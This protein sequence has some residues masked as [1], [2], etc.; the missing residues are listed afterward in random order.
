M[1]II[2]KRTTTNPLYTEGEISLSG[3]QIAN[4]VEHTQTML[5][6]GRYKVYIRKKAKRK[7]LRVWGTKWDI[8]I[9]HSWIDAR[10]K[11]LI[12]IGQPLIPGAVYKSA[13]IYEA[14]L[15][16]AKRCYSRKASITLIIDDSQCQEAK[17]AKHWV[18]LNGER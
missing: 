2:I 17:P 14:L 10:K 18:T 6:A 8:G 12:A 16:R 5:P 3:R 9:A 11:H 7:S 15:K 1:D 13:D 4:T